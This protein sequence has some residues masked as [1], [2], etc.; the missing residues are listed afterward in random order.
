MSQML[1]FADDQ[2]MAELVQETWDHFYNIYRI[3]SFLYSYLVRTD[4]ADVAR[5]ESKTFICTE[6]KYDTVPH[7]KDGVKGILGQWISPEALDKELN[8]RFPGCMKGRVM[9]VIP[10]SMGPI[11]SPLSKIGVQLTDFNYVVLSMRIMARVSSKIWNILGD[12]DFVQ[13]VHS[14]GAPRPVQ[15]K[16]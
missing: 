3:L 4:P 6:K 9:Y 13:C 15:S 11:G 16:Y 1:T 7:V 12:E 2:M 5:V 8:D 14:I 10:Y